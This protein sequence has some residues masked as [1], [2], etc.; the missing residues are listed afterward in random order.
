MMREQQF[1]QE[2]VDL[3]IREWI[4]DM[5]RVKLEDLIFDTN[6]EA[7][8]NGYRPYDISYLGSINYTR[9][10][11]LNEGVEV[12]PRFINI[13]K[14]VVKSAIADKLDPTTNKQEHEFF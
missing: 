10:M 13:S 5:S 1:R 9:D 14:T 8:K 6:K 2:V 4:D 12:P 11:V 7:L 3:A